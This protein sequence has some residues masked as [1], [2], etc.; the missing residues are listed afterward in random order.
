MIRAKLDPRSGVERERK[1]KVLLSL[2]SGWG[3]HYS[4]EA[5]SVASEVE[6]REVAD[7]IQD[8]FF[9]FEDKSIS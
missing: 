5:G 9:F 3:I 7:E 2:R 6:E 4:A 8:P 1:E